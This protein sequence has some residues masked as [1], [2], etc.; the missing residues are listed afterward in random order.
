M[1]K[2]LKPKYFNKTKNIERK[3]NIILHTNV[4]F[5]S[6]NPLPLIV[7]VSQHNKST[8]RTLHKSKVMGPFLC[9]WTCKTGSERLTRTPLGRLWMCKLNILARTPFAGLQIFK[10][11][12]ISEKSHFCCVII[13]FLALKYLMCCVKMSN[14]KKIEL[15]LGALQ[16]DMNVG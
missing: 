10:T 3:E 16:V 7:S 6:H 5:H 4:L 8:T 1:L 12:S 9:L 14:V 15:A 13:A 11:G 2:T